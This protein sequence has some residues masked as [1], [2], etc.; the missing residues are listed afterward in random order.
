MVYM[1]QPARKLLEK[2]AALT[3]CSFA[4]TKHIFESTKK[5]AAFFFFEQR[6]YQNG[7]FYF[8]SAEICCFHLP[9][10][11]SPIS[12]CNFTLFHLSS[13]IENLTLFTVLENHQKCL[14]WSVLGGAKIPIQ[15]ENKYSSLRSYCI[16][17]ETF[18]VFQTLCLIQQNG[19]RKG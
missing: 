1:E 17:N 6:L 4:P 16:K 5:C 13:S 7:F 11:T 12:L 19:A 3:L 8:S 2:K 14:R 10:G 18:W 15:L 9:L